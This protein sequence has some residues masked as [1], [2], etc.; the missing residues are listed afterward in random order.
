M[1]AA[2]EPPELARL[3][4]FAERAR[5]DDWSLRSA[6]CRYAQPQPARVS[7][8]YEPL[9]R[10]DAVL[11]AESARLAKEGP[12]LWAAVQDEAEPADPL[13]GVLRV[14][15]DLDRL[16]DV[17]V[18]WAVDRAAHEPEAD[19]DAAT[20]AAARRLD[21]LGIEREERVS[22]PGMRSRG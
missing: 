11:Q 6:L 12:A 4:D 20:G 10:V 19:V 8:L 14:A 22:P 9:R 13:V 16:A 2:P 17:L 7:A 1:P 3:V 15:Q 18:A 21:E 5:T